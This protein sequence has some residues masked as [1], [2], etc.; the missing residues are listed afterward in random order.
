MDLLEGKEVYPSP[1][2]KELARAK[3]AIE[4]ALSGKDVA[5]ISNGDPGIYGMAGLILEVIRRENVNLEVEIIPGMPAFCAVSSLLGAPLMNDFVL[6]SLSDLLT[7][8]DIIK[9]RIRHAA[10]A[11]F[12]IILYNPSSKGRKNQIKEIN[13]ILLK[14]KDHNTP[15]GIVW[16]AKR[17]G[18][19]VVITTLEKMLS[20]EI[21]MSSTIIIGNS[22][23]FVFDSYMTTK[24]GYKI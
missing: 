9:K 15:V 7:P 22:S 16:N 8:F 11:D 10:E 2:K 23:T 1:M 19:K 13:A 14:Y 20:Y 6:I 21:D 5:I 18:E 3:K 4:I 17:E 12:V 24:R